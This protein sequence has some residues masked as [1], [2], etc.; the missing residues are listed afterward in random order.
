ML[1]EV[2]TQSNALLGDV[3]GDGKVDTTDAK[4]VM[5]YDLDLID[6]TGLELAAADVNGDGQVD[7]TDAKLIMQLDLGLINTFPA[8]G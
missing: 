2:T 7:T 5:Q 4:L 1:V 6:E 8:E 3:N